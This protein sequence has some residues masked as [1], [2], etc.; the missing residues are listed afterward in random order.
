MKSDLKKLE[1]LLRKIEKGQDV[2]EQEL[3]LHCESQSANDAII[4]SLSQRETKDAFTRWAENKPAVASRLP[5]LIAA[6]SKASAIRDTVRDG[7]KTDWQKLRLQMIE[8]PEIFGSAVGLLE[9]L[10]TPSAVSFL[11]TLLEEPLD[12][13]HD[14]TVRRALYRMKQ[15]GIASERPGGPPRQTARELFSLGENRLARWQPM[16]Y[17]RA[18]SAFTDTGDLFVLQLEEGRHFGPV[19][20][21]RDVQIDAQGL[22]QLAERYSESLEKQSG[23]KIGFH[24][25]PSAHARYLLQQ[26]ARLL[27]GSAGERGIGDFLKFIGDETGEYPFEAFRSY[28]GYTPDLQQ[29]S[30]VLEIPYFTHWV[31]TTEELTGFV[32]D[33]EKLEQGPIV[34]PPAK[35]ME[36]RHAA[37]STWLKEYFD[38]KNRAVWGL[39][40]A[41]AAF[42]LRGSDF[43]HAQCA[44]ILSQALEDTETPIENIPAAAFLLEKSA[45]L[46][47]QEKKKQDEKEKETSL[48]MSPAEFAAQ[49]QQRK[50]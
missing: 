41:K 21:R 43:Y 10:A 32:S 35:I 42:F 11:T 3:L 31:F 1:R 18:H 24:A 30:A 36:M 22:E 33:L 5:G 13:L 27:E 44:W 15:K 26:S 19:E 47:L 8:E 28:A 46:I 29:A 40:F 25:A 6:A 39:S 4:Q 50:R 37:G 12:R 49:Q 38:A 45:S 34:L 20:Q 9:L 7:Q 48:I 14:Q 16:L 2:P 17:F 23:M